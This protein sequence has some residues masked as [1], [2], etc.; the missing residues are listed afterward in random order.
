MEWS[1]LVFVGERIEN[2]EWK[3]TR[4]PD[5]N[6]IAVLLFQLPQENSTYQFIPLTNHEMPWIYFSDSNIQVTCHNQSLHVFKGDCELN[7]KQV[8]DVISR[9]ALKDGNRIAVLRLFPNSKNRPQKR[10]SARIVSE[11]KSLYEK[12]SK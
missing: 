2:G 6:D 4:P 10:K 1:S 8:I 9:F 12:S 11:E 7:E 5:P 3:M